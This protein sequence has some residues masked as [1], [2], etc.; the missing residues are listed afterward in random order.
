M[1][2]IVL[3][4]FLLA[5]GFALAQQKDNPQ[6]FLDSLLGPH[7]FGKN[8]PKN[9]RYQNMIDSIDLEFDWNKELYNLWDCYCPWL[10][11]DSAKTIMP[12]ELS[13][14]K[15][16]NKDKPIIIDDSTYQQWIKSNLAF[17][18]LSA[19]GFAYATEPKQA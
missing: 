15:W 18:K 2:F 16:V 10:K 4:L 19:C 5:S 11:A 12:R 14:Y 7:P 9:L 1:K 3:L 13:P 8:P 6:K 17:K